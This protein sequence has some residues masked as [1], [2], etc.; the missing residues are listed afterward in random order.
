MHTNC[1]ECGHEIQYV[2]RANFI[3]FCPACL[4]YAF[5]QC[6][7]GYG[8][9]VPCQIYLGDKEIGV[10]TEENYNYYLTRHDTGETIPLKQKYLEALQEAVAVIEPALGRA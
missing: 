10:V 9:V 3:I 5:L 4:K 7:Y 8:P 2:P 1:K 6:E